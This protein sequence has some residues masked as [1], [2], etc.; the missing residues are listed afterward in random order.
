MHH[1]LHSDEVL[2]SD[3]T[4]VIRASQVSSFSETQETDKGWGR[5]YFREGE[6][7][8]PLFCASF[9]RQLFSFDWGCVLGYLY[10]SADRP[11]RFVK[12]T[13]GAGGIVGSRRRRFFQEASRCKAA[14]L[15]LAGLIEANRYMLLCGLPQG[16]IDGDTAMSPDGRQMYVW[17][18]FL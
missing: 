5:S 9:E 13:N 16:E 3:L 1:F 14:L 12:R 10:V 18:P 11:P 15:V 17:R 8:V 4:L 7:D 2:T 6:Y